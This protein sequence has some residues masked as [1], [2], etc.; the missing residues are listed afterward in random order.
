MQVKKKTLRF[1]EFFLIGVVLGIFEDVLAVWFATGEPITPKVI[2][3][4]FLVALPFAVI[5][6]YIVDHPKFWRTI[7]GLKDNNKVEK[8]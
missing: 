6:E 2:G 5:S 8:R 1:L 3:I 4:V 7:F